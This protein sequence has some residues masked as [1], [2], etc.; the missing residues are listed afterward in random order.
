[1]TLRD[2]HSTR[3]VR[4]AALDVLRRLGLTTI[5]ANPGSTEIPFLGGLPDEMTFHLA[6][7][8]GS[9]VGMATGWAL[10]QGRPALVNLHT[11]AGLGN[12][13]GAVATA[14]QNRVPLVVVVGQQDR[15]HLAL[16]P[17]LAGRLDGLAGEYPVWTHQIARPQDVPGALARAY[18]EAVTGRGPA[19][20]VV[21]MDD[22]DAP[23][24]EVR[25][26]APLVVRRPLTAI[27]DEADELTGW[28]DESVSPVIV[29]GSGNDDATSWAAL[30]ELAEKLGAP[31]W[32]EAFGARAGFPQDHPAFAGHLPSGRTALREVLAGHDLLLTVGAP[33][34][35][36]YTWEPGELVPAG[37]RVAQITAYP[38]EAHNSIADLTVIADPARLCWHLA[39]QVRGRAAT[40]SVRRVPD[41]VPPPGR[42]E[43]L[44]PAHVFDLLARHLPA[45]A[46]LVEES[47]SSRPELHRR[48]PA[49]TSLGFLSAAGGGLGFGLPAAVGVRLG[50]PQRPVVAVLG[51]GSSLYGIQG[52]WS[53]AHYQIGVLLLVLS[54]GGYAVM[55]RLAEQAGRG[56]APWPRFEEVRISTLAA[57][58]GCPTQRITTHDQ[59]SEALADLLPTLADR[60]APLLLDID[61][62]GDPT[63]G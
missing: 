13:V 8:E 54:N 34:L 36:Q 18:H 27:G 42:D 37:T 31:V 22:W 23:S 5:F 11:T 26:A 16:D 32:Q 33:A 39:G 45:D 41:P 61:V 63:Y 1:M 6:L 60:T 44:R 43:P 46:V 48:V 14:R 7:H 62:A 38:D 58:L 57:G 24:D 47:P 2:E 49:R 30:V 15:R 40:A 20:L 10:A 12:A 29:A 9:V 35:R 25:D 3:S 51:D 19:I 56:K 52:L 59:L 50:A 4:D 53:A 55:D 21:P 17:F 28:L